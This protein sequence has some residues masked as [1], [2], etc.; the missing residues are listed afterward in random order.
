L[1]QKEE[2]TKEYS[3]CRP[4][5][6]CRDENAGQNHNIKI[7][8]ISLETVELFGYFGTT[9]TNRNSIH[10]EIKS[11]VKSGNAC[12]QSVKNLFQAAIQKYKD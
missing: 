1:L 5:H 2:N 9:L 12:Y 6:L 4:I 11:R 8:N 10:E 7:N 3:T